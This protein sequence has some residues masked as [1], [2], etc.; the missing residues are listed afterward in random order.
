MEGFDEEE[1]KKFFPSGFGKQTKEADIKTQIDRTKRK[2][3]VE[4]SNARAIEKASGPSQESTN[5]KDDAGSDAD[6][7]S[8]S[9][10]SDDEF[11]VSHNL[12]FKT[13]ERAVTTITL[14][15]AGARM[16]TG[17]T[18]CTV[19]FHDFASLTPSTLR[20]FKSVEPNARKNATSSSEIHPVHIAKFNP[21]S[22]S[23]I[24]VVSATPQAKVLSRD[25]DTLAE[26]VKGDMYLRDMKNTKGHISEVTSGT[27]SPSDYNLCVTAGTDST[28]R[29][30]DVNDPRSQ[31][32]VIVHRSRA[33]GSAGRS[34]MTAVAWASPAQGG[35]NALIASA[36]DG[37]LVMWGGDGPFN[38]PSAEIKDA[39]TKDTWTSGLDISPD[40]RLVVTKGGDDMIKLWDTRKFKQPITT[41]SHVSGSKFYPTSNIQFSPSGANIV[42]GS[43]TGH[44][45]ILNPA[46]LKP[47]MVTLVTPDSPLISVY[48]HEKLNQII[49]GSANAETH[50]LY[51]PSLSHNGALMIMSKAPK[52][53]HVDDDP[54]FTTDISLGFS[55]EGI[56]NGSGIAAATSFAARHPTVG[57][58]A[59]G[60]SRDPRRPHVPAQTPFAKSQPD[61]KHIKDNIPLSSMRD[62]DPREALLKYAEAAEKEPIF[63]HAWKHTQPKTIYAEL[64]DDD[65]EE[66]SKRPGP[67]KKRIKRNY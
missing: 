6:S 42:T 26:F 10:G 22:P 64:S 66:E 58:T 55:G 65:E 8:D 27:W 43:E 11:P 31:K 40:G 12:V 28:L 24:L 52:R 54:N 23:Q 14:D 29:I 61:E 33:A 36:L 48:W 5:D 9:D 35:P 47:E 62:E 44:L 39:H 50:L 37:S 19:K 15:T 32:E 17:S 46:T 2:A 1:F 63:T 41:V 49:T 60:R 59:S 38:R 56:V 45:H 16:I 25:G 20:A 13:H 34:R 4:T 7:D 21:I 57:L 51:N 3:A 18:D 53:R 30:W 67:D